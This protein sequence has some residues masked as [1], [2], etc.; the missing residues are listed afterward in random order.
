M[1][2][3]LITDARLLS[4]VPCTMYGTERAL[5]FGRYSTVRYALQAHADGDGGTDKPIHPYC[6]L[7]PR[8]NA[9]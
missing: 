6:L 8:I 4:L 2:H 5:D 7:Q 9:P 1:T 3:L